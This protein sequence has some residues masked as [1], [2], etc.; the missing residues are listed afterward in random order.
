MALRTGKLPLSLLEEV[1]VWRGADDPAVRLGPAVGEDAAVVDL[2]DRYLVLKTDPITFAQEEVGWYAVHANANDV[3]TRGARPRWFQS[4]ILFPRGTE[5]EEVRRVFRQVH[6]ACR[7]LEVAVTGGHAEVTGAV[8]RVVVVGDMQGLGAKEDLV[9]TG[10]AREG[11]DLLLTKGAGIEGTAVLAR[12]AGEALE[13]LVGPET[14][15]RAAAFLRDPGLSVVPEA[16]RAAEV[17]ATALHDPTEGGVAMGLLELSLACGH[18]V[19]VRPASIPVAEATR[20]LCEAT[21]L[22]PLSLLASGALLVAVPPDRSDLLLDGL[23]Q[24]RVPATKI[25][26][27]GRAGRGVR[28]VGTGPYPLEPSERDEVARFLEERRGRGRG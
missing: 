21:G 5:E 15:R 17:G 9:T 28:T 22:N 26:K 6:E 11:D 3:A 8:D 27:V 25:G 1:L 24:L 18:E 20:R 10:G 23:R 14:V 16:I 4:A 7:D 2:G 19:L 12:E 13:A